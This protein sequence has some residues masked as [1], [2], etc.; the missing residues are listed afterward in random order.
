[1]TFMRAAL[2]TAQGKFARGWGGK[3]RTA[4]P[5]TGGTLTLF[6]LISLSITRY[7]P[8]RRK[9]IQISKN[10]LVMPVTR[11]RLWLAIRT[12]DIP[13]RVSRKRLGAFDQVFT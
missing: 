10:R 4:Q 2:C 8:A 1:M 7:P 5:S 9:V 11:G 12:S 3:V 6:P 13:G